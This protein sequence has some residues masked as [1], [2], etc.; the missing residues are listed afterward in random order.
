MTV[1]TVGMITL[2][3]CK[4]EETNNTINK[5]KIVVQ[6]DAPLTDYDGNVYTTVKIGN[7]VWMA[8][9]LRVTHFRNGTAI[10]PVQAANDWL[11]N[12]TKAA[13]CY[14]DNKLDSIAFYGALY[15]G[16]AIKSSNNLAPAGWRIP[17]ASDLN[18]LRAYLD[19]FSVAEGALKASGTTFWRSPNTGGTNTTL[20][21]A[22][23]AGYRFV[24]G[25][26]KERGFQAQWWL[27]NG[28]SSFILLYDE[29]TMQTSTS[30]SQY[31]FSVRCIKE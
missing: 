6:Q 1:V 18:Q 12:T 30:T 26:F 10:F 24:N 9:N 16:T 3:A 13:Y 5:P 17:T 31:G 15:N 29:V 14:Y 25:D 28:T 4:K 21:N 8:E 19:S 20:F 22:L 7:Q 27:S 23:P 2:A 11:N